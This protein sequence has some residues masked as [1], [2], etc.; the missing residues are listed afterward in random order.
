VNVLKPYLENTVR[1]LLANGVSQREIARK[2][3]V[4]R[5]TIRKYQGCAEHA[6]AKS[7]SPATGEGASPAQNPPPRPPTS[8]QWARSQCEAH[9]EWIEAQVRL[10]RNAMAIYQEL[11]DTRGF[12]AR[13][14][15]VKRFCAKLRKREPE[16]FDR[17]EFAPGEEAQVDYGEGALTVHPVSGKYRRP[18][19][20]VMTLRFSRRSFRKVVWK[21]SAEQWARLHEEAFRY[22]GGC[23]RYVVLDN[24]K[25]GV[26]K[27]DLYEPQ[28]NRLYAA[29]LNHYGVAADPARVRDPNRKGTVE[30]AIQHTQSTALK[31]KRFASLEEQNAHLMQWEQKW[32]ASR[33]HG[34][35]QRQV[36]QM[37][38]E[39]RPQLKALPL[40]PFQY[41]TEGVRT[42]GDDTTVQVE[43]SWYAA[44]PAR[45]GTQV[46]VRVFAHELEIRHLTTLAL[47]R[48]HG[49]AY[50]SGEVHLPERER[51]FNPSR[52]TEYLLA[53]A[54]E[55][56]PHTHALCQKLFAQR[57]REGQKTMWGLVALVPRWPAALIEQAV[58]LAVGRGHE[59]LRAV[60]AIL[61][62][63]LEC[64]LEVLE[65]PDTA[66]PLT[67]QH[68]LI[69]SPAQYADFFETS[70]R[71]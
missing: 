8:A 49:R 29:M 18:R 12:A 66:N 28:L 68:E 30:S 52:Q 36:E 64:A 70:V 24:L 15:S 47:L 62:E 20:F 10:G 21:S 39:E 22:F 71:R 63:R 50:R 40:A 51:L 26:I 37:Y 31:G 33:I 56:G 14:N 9:R 17:L 60:R 61:E 19:L 43:G 55:L 4:D 2:T 48:R 35:A 57:G 44:S 45:I 42:V 6:E 54:R 13:Y 38:Q 16:Q 32:A 69:R 34:R 25:E 67:Q 11:V 27:P 59:S 41:F 53:R 7:S 58:E 23:T 1:T 65:S 5:K 46:L 3:G